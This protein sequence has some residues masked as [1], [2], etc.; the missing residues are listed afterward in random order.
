MSALMN[1]TE[2]IEWVKRRLGA[3]IL[4]LP[5][6]DENY[7]DAITS[8]KHWFV[9]KKGIERDVT[10]DLYA[11]Q[12]EYSVPDD[13]DAVIDVSF[14]VSP[15][16]ISLIFAPNVVS[17]E[18]IPYSVFA[19][20]QSEGM[21]STFVQSLQYVET[22][23]RILG[24][25]NNWLYFPYKKKLYIFPNPKWGGKA[26]IE[27]KSSAVTDITQL[28]ER[29]HDLIKRYTLASAKKDLATMFSRYAS[30]PTAQ[31]QTQLNGPQLM[32]EAEEEL[33]TLK[34]EITNS[35]LPMPFLVG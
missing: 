21:Y 12:V 26:F 5:L 22:A 28:P 11:G 2:L 15:L 24:A 4:K 6:T 33:A 35:A 32:K 17:D 27:Y 34:E 19:A 30:M 25:E 13:C 18:R 31:G 23:K 8:A 9:A 7:T 29:D 10:I 14:Q 1:E 3:P 16:D 20:P